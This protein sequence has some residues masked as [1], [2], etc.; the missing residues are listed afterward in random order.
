MKKLIILLLAA[1][2]TAFSACAEAPASPFAPYTLTA[3]ADVTLTDNEGS[4]TFVRGATR[5]VTLVISRVPDEDPAAALPVLMQQFDA[6]A[7]LG[8][9]LLLREGFH[10]LTAVTTDKF[11]TGVD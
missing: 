4:C 9:D 6:Y 10:G 5:V 3:P 7:I 8:E 1:L 11:G 2:M